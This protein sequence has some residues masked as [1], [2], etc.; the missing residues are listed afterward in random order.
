MQWLKDFINGF[1]S[2]LY[3]GFLWLVEGIISALSYFLYTLYDGF[4]FIVWAIFAGIDCSELMFDLGARYAGLPE[5]LIWLVNAVDLPQALTYI[6]FG[7]ITRM[8][9]NVIPAA[10]T[11]I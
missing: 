7:I 3:D 1:F 6:V 4:L 2:L 8:W 9:L 10:L 5:Q 11:R